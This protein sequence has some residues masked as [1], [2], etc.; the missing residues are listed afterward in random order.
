MQLVL[1]AQCT[2]IVCLSVLTDPSDQNN[3]SPS[4]LTGS[5]ECLNYILDKLTANFSYG[6]VQ[7][8]CYYCGITIPQVQY[9]TTCLFCST[10]VVDNAKLHLRHMLSI[11]QNIDAKHFLKI[12]QSG[13]MSDPFLYLSKFL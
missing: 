11:I 2:I 12:P 7:W 10:S 9:H 1:T 6:Q 8:Q 5:E 13:D 3:P 4:I